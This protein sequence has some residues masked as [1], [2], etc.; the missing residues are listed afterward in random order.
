MGPGCL[1]GQTSSAAYA[2]TCGGYNA[3]H[4]TMTTAAVGNTAWGNGAGGSVTSGANGTYL[5]NGAGSNITTG[6]GI[7]VGQGVQGISASVLGEINI[8][9]IIFANNNSTA[10]PTVTAC[11]TNSIDTYANNRSGTV[12]ITAGTPTSCT[13]T[14]AGTG[15]GT[16]NH[17][18]VTSQSVNAAFAY[19][20]TKT[21]L[22]V[23]GTAL[24][25]KI[26]Y[27]CDGV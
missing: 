4:G 9:G 19:S 22:T 1:S 10:A 11:G 16:W 15:Y 17:C 13:I 7:F 2:N 6:N 12:I 21:V 23:T 14:F 5:G 24:A 25:G 20:Y 18:R 27:D 3:L 26:D 8:G